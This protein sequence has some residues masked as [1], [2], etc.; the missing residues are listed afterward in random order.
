MQRLPSHLR[1]AIGYSIDHIKEIF[2]NAYKSSKMYKK[3]MK[4]W[5]DQHIHQR[6]F[7]EANLVLPFNSGL[8]LFS[9]KLR[10]RW[11]GPL[12]VMKVYPYGAIDIGTEAT[13]TLIM[14]WVAAQALHCE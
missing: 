8:N 12:K 9:G 10:S 13:R 5:Y 7:R 1:G 6:E 11:S 3:R 14:K 4:I 2:S